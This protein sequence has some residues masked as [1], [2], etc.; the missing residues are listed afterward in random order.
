M[1][2]HKRLDIEWSVDGD[3]DGYAQCPRCGHRLRFEH[4]PEAILFTC[5]HVF[6]ANEV[7]DDWMPLGACGWFAWLPAI[8]PPRH[9]PMH[10]N[11]Y[12]GRIDGEDA[13]T[14]GERERD[15][16]AVHS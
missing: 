1:T 7:G 3:G 6:P 4:S 12:R 15:V 2:I 14:I 5:M 16:S 9:A 10:V 13:A 8:E 11:V